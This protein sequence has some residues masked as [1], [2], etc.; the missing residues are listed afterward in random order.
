LTRLPDLWAFVRPGWAAAVGEDPKRRLALL[1]LLMLPISGALVFAFGFDG[2]RALEV[3]QRHR[4]TVLSFVGNAPLLAGLAFVAVYA[5]AVATSLPA[6]GVLTMVGGYLFGWLSGSLYV[7][8]ASSGAGALVFLLA[9]RALR[10]SGPA[11][12]KP[13]LRRFG[14]GFRKNATTFVFVLHLMPI[15]P[16]AMVIG[17]PAACGVKLRVYVIGALLGL[18]PG[19]LLLARLGSGLGAALE[20]GVALRPGDLMSAEIV[21]SLAGLGLLALLPLLYRGYQS[22]Q[23]R[24]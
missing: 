17:L 14:D 16:Y 9:R 7:L 22:W 10:G 18:I 1:L 6:V 8:V 19:T 2:E 21:L 12:L 4:L 11:A 23:A 24:R 13:S 3:L 5:L 15:F 20:R